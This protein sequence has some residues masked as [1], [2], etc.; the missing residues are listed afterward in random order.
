MLL[1]LLGI[2]LLP[3]LRKTGI[4]CIT[5]GFVSLYLLSTAIVAHCLIYPLQTIQPL[6]L[7]TLKK[8]D[9]SEK[10]IVVLTGGGRYAPEYQQEQPSAHS[11]V[12][13][14]YAATLYRATQLPMIILG[15]KTGYFALS[16][17]Q[18]MQANL[19]E[20]DHIPTYWLDVKSRNTRENAQYTQM[21]LRS[22]EWDRF[23]LVTSAWH[24]PRAI[25]WFEKLSMQPTPAPTDYL[26]VSTNVLTVHAW[27]P[28][29]RMLMISSMALHEYW[30][31]ISNLR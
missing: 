15:G 29:A 3:L 23:Y 10:A 27:L 24:M 17:A 16:E 2:L 26:D 25:Q 31:K 4:A 9:R 6:D 30:G 11:L 12:R 18:M 21:F 1:M 14:N 7:T 19:E 8:Q 13:E 22:K 20:N 5:L 28:Q